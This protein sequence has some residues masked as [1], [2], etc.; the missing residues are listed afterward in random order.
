[1]V[2]SWAQTFQ[3]A[4]GEIADLL[5]VDASGSVYVASNR[6]YPLA[7]NLWIIRKLSSL[8]QLQWTQSFFAEGSPQDM[9]VDS[10]GHLFLTSYI[11]SSTGS[12]NEL[13][14]RLLSNGEVDWI[15]EY[16][17]AVGRAT[18]VDAAGNYYVA[19]RL[20]N[21]SGY[22]LLLIEYNNT[23]QVLNIVKRP[24]ITPTTMF[25]APNG[26]LIAVGYDPNTTSSMFEVFSPGGTYLYSS[27]TSDTT[28]DSY[29]Y[30]M[31]TDAN[32]DLFLVV[33]DSYN[34]TSD[35]FTVECFDSQGM[36]VWQ[37]A[38]E[39]GQP[40]QVTAGDTN[41]AYVLASVGNNSFVDYG[42]EAGG[43]RFMNVQSQGGLIAADGTRGLVSVTQSTTAYT[44]SEINRYLQTVWTQTYTPT[45]LAA[46]AKLMVVNSTVYGL[47]LTQDINGLPTT[48]IIKFVQGVGAVSVTP[49]KASIQGGQPVDLTVQLNDITSASGLKVYFL[50]DSSALGL[51][52]SLVIPAGKSSLTVTA[53]TTPVDVATTVSI[54][55]EV[56]GGIRTT[57]VVLLPAV[58]TAVTLPSGANS[59][60]KGGQT[61]TGTIQL[62]GPTALLAHMVTLSSNSAKATVSAT[63]SVLPGA[64]TATF[65]VH[66]TTVTA[67]TPVVITA[68]LAGVSLT[69]KLTVTP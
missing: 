4:D 65:V 22:E 57:K 69:A 13:N 66:T 11:Q 20:I 56:N 61:I 55:A 25:F 43:H 64:S 32:S 42:Y 28:T 1:V 8:G 48:N 27:I 60:V 47:N 68:K 52:A 14:I 49:S 37:T 53:L 38:S 29:D 17:D 51:P 62:S 23:G 19:G 67:N 58:L 16:P 21:G 24:E 3:S 30:R 46:S 50:S 63:V 41:H 54:A 6:Y 12:Y 44:Y 9:A 26:N 45:R 59:S 35:S 2:Q 7:G 33:H 15:T 5:A 18:Y 40:Y 39:V 31:A 36:T 10:T 34:H